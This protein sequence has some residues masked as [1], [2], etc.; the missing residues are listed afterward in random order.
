[1]LLLTICRLVLILSREDVD[2]IT[3]QFHFMNKQAGM[4]VRRRHRG[5][6]H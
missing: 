5:H 1:M 4:D 2:E 6:E 3:S